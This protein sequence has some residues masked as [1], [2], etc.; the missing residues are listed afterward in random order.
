[1]RTKKISSSAVY[2]IESWQKQTAMMEKLEETETE[3]SRPVSTAK[4]TNLKRWKAVLTFK[5]KERLKLGTHL[6]TFSTLV[7]SERG[8][9]GRER[10]EAYCRGGWMEP[11]EML[12]SP[13]VIDRS[14]GLQT[15]RTHYESNDS[16]PSSSLLIGG[17]LQ[18]RTDAAKADGAAK[19]WRQCCRC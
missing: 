17:F 12:R 5:K 6:T 16:S 4:K 11:I 9:N 18:T 8:E 3:R 1:M 10:V 13:K 14:E 2:V 7:T 15:A 19:R